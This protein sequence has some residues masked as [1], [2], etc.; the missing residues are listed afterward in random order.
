MKKIKKMVDSINDE[1]HGAKEYAETAIEYKV[2]GDTVRYNDYKTMAN[3]ELTHADALHKMTVEDIEALKK[4]YPDPPQ[5]ML[6]KWNKA[7]KEY[8]EKYAWIKQILAM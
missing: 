6:D 8:I 3:Q 7:H 1:L 4:V 2:L 5:S